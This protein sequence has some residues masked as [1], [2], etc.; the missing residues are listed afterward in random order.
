[1]DDVSY[2]ATTPFLKDVPYEI[3][4]L[5]VPGAPATLAKRLPK[6]FQKRTPRQL[7]TSTS[8]ASLLG[9]LGPVWGLPR[10][11]L[12]HLGAILGLL[13]GPPWGYLGTSSGLS[14]GVLGAV[15]ACQLSWGVLGLSWRYPGAVLGHLGPVLG[16][17]GV[18]L[19]LS[20]GCLVAVLGP[21]GAVLGLSCPVLGPSSGCLGALFL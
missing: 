5:G 20:W 12:G 10:A 13:G 17:L 2:F 8:L 19:G 7:G 15:L 21:L 1:M 4:I 14:W 9:C 16:S 6:G 3:V 11:V 18:L